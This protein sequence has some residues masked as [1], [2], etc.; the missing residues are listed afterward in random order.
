MCVLL[1]GVP[2]LGLLLL[3]LL[4]LLCCIPK[5]DGGDQGG[6]QTGTDPPRYNLRMRP[7]KPAIDHGIYKRY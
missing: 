3:G 2:A 7:T 1:L 5:K 6:G 4:Y